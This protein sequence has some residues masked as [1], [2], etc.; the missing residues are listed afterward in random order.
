MMMALAPLGTLKPSAGTTKEALDLKDCH[1]QSFVV[2]CAEEEMLNYNIVI[3]LYK[4]WV[5]SMFS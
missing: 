3:L 1:H 4:N 2:N 5:L